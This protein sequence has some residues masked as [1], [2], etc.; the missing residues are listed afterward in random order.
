ME[1]DNQKRNPFN[2]K[3]YC[4][5]IHFQAQIQIVFNVFSL[6]MILLWS[7]YFDY[8]KIIEP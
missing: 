8:F 2:Y 6:K 3:G 5:D 1:K 4:K 7:R